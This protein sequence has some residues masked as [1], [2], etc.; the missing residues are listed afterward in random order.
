MERGESVSLK[1][2]RVGWGTSPLSLPAII[3]VFKRNYFS[4]FSNPAG[5]V[6]ITL[7]VLVCAWGEFW[8]PTF[9]ANNLADLAPLNQLMPYLLLFFIPA[10]TMSTWAEE[11]RLGTDELLLTL[12][13]RDSDVVIG[14][15]LA[16][17]GIY[18]T[19]LVFSLSIV[20]I[21]YTLGTPDPGV[22]AATYFG[23][24]LMG[25]AIAAIGLVAS[26]LSSNVTV[27]FI[28]GAVFAAIPVFVGY[29]A[30]MVPQAWKPTI[31]RLGIPRQFGDS[32][33]AGVI[34][35]DGVFYFVTLA[36]TMLY[37]NIFLLG[38]RHWA[39]GQRS[40]VIWAHSIIR[41]AAVAIAFISVD[42]LITRHLPM[43]RDISE[44][45]L[46]RL[47]P[48][49]LRLVGEIS[50]DRPVYIEAYYTETVPRELVQTK[51]D[52]LNKLREF[53]AE[54]RGSIRL[55]LVPTELY[56]AEAREAEK[57]YGITPRPIVGV[58][59]AKQER[60]E[61]FL[62]VAFTSGL[63]EVIVPFFD[64]GLPVEYE[65]ARSIR[66]VSK[67]SRKKLGVLQ[68]DA[69]LLGGFD[70]RSMGQNNEW[71]VVSELKKQYEVSSVSADTP[72]PTDLDVL[73]V[74][75]PSSLT[76]KQIDNLIA[77]VKAGKATLLFLD[78]LP[79]VDPQISPELPRQ[80]P[81]GQFGG[82]PPPEP[83][84]DLSPLLD[85]LGIDWPTSEIVWDP[86][87]P[88]PNLGRDLPPE[89]V[90]VAKGGG[91]DDAFNS[92][93][94]ASAGL[95]EIVMMFGG[96]LRAKS[97]GP[98]FIP[99]LRSSRQGG[100]IPW[101]RIVTPT[102]MGGMSI[103]PSAPHSA[104]GIAYTLAARVQGK[105]ATPKTSPAED[106]AKA[107]AEAPSNASINAIVIADL[108]MISEQFFELRRR[109]IENL[110]FDNVT[111]VLNCVDVLAGDDSYIDLRKRRLA[112]RTLTK[113]EEKT[114]SFVDS[115]QKESKAA[116]DA[117][118]DQLAAAQKRLD[119]KIEA[120]RKRTDL[121]D[122]TKAV[123]IAN[124]ESVEQRRLDV[125][126]A[127]IDDERRKKLLAS[128]A[129]TEMNIR[130]IQRDSRLTAL[131]LPPLPAVI[132]GL[133]VLA[134]RAGRE[135]QG[136][137]PKRLA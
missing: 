94:P 133:F 61:V 19:A 98:E 99:L 113:L 20:G 86:Y 46:S 92:S 81:G 85:L 44:E 1:P 100:T 68:T 89:I 28:L 9:F 8:Q 12:P 69:K 10:I 108:D 21:L 51:D 35:L 64:K 134:V 124:S 70:F 41:I 88:H 49:S 132:L 31:E 123:M 127:T 128:K 43:R 135:N 17:V 78:P 83:K 33:T 111:F 56:S 40:G 23:Y 50:K 53:A 97:G 32:F 47:S 115:Q 7:F 39:G 63:D 110:D 125:E 76:Q 36:F 26:V 11:R 112:H 105:A 14:K 119:E 114:K 67:T 71:P 96:Q 101:S 59:D 54:S 45:G 22:I 117:A 16:A 55:N 131:L 87:S 15:F 13:A 58:E 27:A 95:Q 66:V 122:R 116:E 109:K 34:P 30:T 104:S 37:V 60:D 137:S 42:I 73:L 52:L 84:G 82:G 93:Q 118:T 4:Y 65:L 29:V 74:A 80:S 102:M 107:K 25:V 6:F 3:A 72:I 77:H 121:D 24:W 90:F 18:T 129:D 38:R 48:E 57:K 2:E 106:A 62:G 126:K 79:L 75:Q 130:A 136:A 91:G 5:Y 120:L 103:N